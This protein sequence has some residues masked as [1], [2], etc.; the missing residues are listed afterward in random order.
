M[1]VSTASCP[2]S[3]PIHPCTHV[4]EPP[5]QNPTAFLTTA[6]GLLRQLWPCPL[7]LSQSSTGLT[8]DHLH[9]CPV[10]ATRWS[11]PASS[12]LLLLQE[13]HAW[14]PVPTSQPLSL[15]QHSTAEAPLTLH[16]HRTMLDSPFG[17]SC[18]SSPSRWKALEVTLT[19][20]PPHL[21]HI[22]SPSLS[23]ALLWSL[24][25]TALCLSRP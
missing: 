4:L 21:D 1:S 2:H 16:G 6:S 25:S 12:F 7:A 14:S 22:P 23:S 20:T 15:S 10:P 11:D 5:T 17:G 13:L 24:P 19:H 9:R 18:S 8:P 3:L